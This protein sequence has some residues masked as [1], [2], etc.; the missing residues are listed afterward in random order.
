MKNRTMRV[1][2]LLLVLTLMTSC[3]VG[4]TFAKYTT[5]GTSTDTARVAKWGVTVTGATNSMFGKAYKSADGTLSTTYEAATDSVHANDDTALLVA[6]GT[7]GTLNGFSVTGTPEVDVKVSYTADLELTG[8]TI[9]TNGA[10]DGGETTYFPIVITITPTTGSA[11]T[12]TFT[13]GDDIDAFETT[14]ENAIK[15]FSH[16]YEAGTELDD[17]FANDFT[18]SWAWAYEGND[19]NDTLLGNLN[20]APQ[21]SLTVTCTIDQVD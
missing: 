5:N 9:D 2:A 7:N 11:Q 16:N 10:E 8:W 6:P 3:F 21:I 1:A 15:A 14:V 20:T 12:Y 13:T 19:T 4:G 18:I 17:D